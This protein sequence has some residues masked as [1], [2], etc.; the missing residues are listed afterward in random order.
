MDTASAMPPRKRGRGGFRGRSSHSV[1]RSSSV[2]PNEPDS[3]AA[4]PA[5][6]ERSPYNPLED[7]WTDEQ[8]TSLF[9]G[10]IQWKPAG[11]H[12]HFR[13]IALSE[14]LRNHGYNEVHTQIPGIW[15]KLGKLYDLDI[16]DEQE[17]VLDFGEEGEE[18]DSRWRE[19][20]L[21]DE[22]AVMAFERGKRDPD[23]E[24]PSSPPRLDEEIELPT[25]LP[26]TTR[27]RRRGAGSVRNSSVEMEDMPT[28]PAPPP[29]SVRGSA[30]GRGRGRG[31][32]RPVVVRS[33]I[34][35]SAKEDTSVE[36]T[37]QEETA[38]ETGEDESGEESTAEE[39][40]GGSP[41]PKATRGRG[42]GRGRGGRG[43]RR[44][45]KRGR[46]A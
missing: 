7:P 23:D 30:R 3:T 38:D 28:S 43:G 8:E 45:R 46:G 5:K 27:K 44:G 40:E 6:R 20:E 39:S 35:R 26:A 21:P 14:H 24:T 12:K 9:K 25:P 1:S 37:E 4:S 10:L 19:F 32:G 18:R 34:E 31:R 2:A 29:S 22:I 42:R 17:N 36:N 41:S 13:M 33:S 15:E 16:I 11:I